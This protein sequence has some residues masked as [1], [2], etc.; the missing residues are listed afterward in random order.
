MT[1]RNIKFGD[2]ELKKMATQ[3]EIFFCWIVANKKHIIFG[4]P[5]LG[6]DGFDE[7]IHLKLKS[8]D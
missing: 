6:L 4:H 1:P 7:I 2:S 8:V 5:D 3:L